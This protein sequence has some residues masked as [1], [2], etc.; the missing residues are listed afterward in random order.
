[1]SLKIWKSVTAKYARLIARSAAKAWRFLRNKQV[2]LLLRLKGCSVDW[3]AFVH[4]DAVLNLSGGKIEIGPYTSIDK[5]VIIRAMGGFVTVGSNCNVNAYSF[6]SGGGGLSIADYVMI[7][8][9]VSIYASNHIFSDTT[10][11]MATQGL[12]MQGIYIR[13]DVWI[14]TGARILD[15]VEVAQGCVIAAGAVVTKSTLPYT[16]NGGIP[17]RAIGSRLAVTWPA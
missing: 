14:G 10:K 17:S 1:M 15:G 8:S 3:S 6:L 9:H 5:G 2:I 7:A 16:I 12:I 4:P 13:K 11:P